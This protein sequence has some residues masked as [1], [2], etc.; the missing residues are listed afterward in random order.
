[1]ADATVV[2]LRGDYIFYTYDVRGA[3][4]TASQDISGLLHLLP[5]APDW[6]AMPVAIRYDPRN[7]ANSIILAEDWNGLRKVH[8]HT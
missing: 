4:Y 1:M 2:E 7:A 3:R 5:D 8:P 6:A